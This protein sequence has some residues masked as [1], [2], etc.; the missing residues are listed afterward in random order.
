MLYS[1]GPMTAEGS[2]GVLYGLWRGCH[3]KEFLH[4][5]RETGGQRA[6]GIGAAST[7]STG[8]TAPTAP[9]R[10]CGGRTAATFVRAT[11]VC[12]ADAAGRVRGAATATRAADADGAQE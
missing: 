1:S 11:F 5:V 8:S 6:G 12:A 7:G 2:Y 10:G 3:G 4:D 9:G